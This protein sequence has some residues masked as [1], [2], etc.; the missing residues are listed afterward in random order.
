M[1]CRL[2]KSYPTVNA[3]N[4]FF[5]IGNER[6]DQKFVK[7]R[8]QWKA[9]LLYHQVKSDQDYKHVVCKLRT[10]DGS[11]VVDTQVLKVACKYPSSSSFVCYLVLELPFQNN[12]FFYLQPFQH[13]SS[14]LEA[15]CHSKEKFGGERVKALNLF[16]IS[17]G[18]QRGFFNLK[19]S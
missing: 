5:E 12:L 14:L 9:S 16:R 15:E 10:D 17:H 13:Q 11:L 19:L 1:I 18:D 7:V 8:S 2:N 4:I 6:I 3:N